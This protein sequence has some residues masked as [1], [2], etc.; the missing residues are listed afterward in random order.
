MLSSR[1]CIIS[2]F[3][4]IFLI[5]LEG[6]GVYGVRYGY[7]SPHHLLKSQSLFQPL[8][9]HLY[10]ALNFHMYLSYFWTLILFH[11]SVCLFMCQRNFLFITFIM[12]YQR[13][14]KKLD[15]QLQWSPVSLSP[16]WRNNWSPSIRPE[17]DRLRRLLSCKH[18]L[19]FLS[20]GRMTGSGQTAEPRDMENCSQGLKLNPGT[21]NISLAEFQNCCGLGTPL[22]PSF[23]SPEQGCL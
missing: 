16:S 1:A 6:I 19:P 2:F 10:H 15:E 14:I 7:L 8:K 11:W 21:F 9:C 4:C 5:H 23:P 17:G 12:S 13:H 3:T 22:C 20:R 18:F